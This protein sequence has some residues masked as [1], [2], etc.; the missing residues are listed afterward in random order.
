MAGWLES[1]LYGQDDPDIKGEPE[2]TEP[3]YSATSPKLI[4]QIHPFPAE[5]WGRSPSAFFLVILMEW[6]WFLWMDSIHMEI[7][8]Q[9]KWSALLAHASESY[10]A[11]TGPAYDMSGSRN[12]P[13]SQQRWAVY[14]LQS[15]PSAKIKAVC[16]WFA[17]SRWS[18]GAVRCLRD[19]VGSRDDRE[20]E[21]D[22][23]QTL[24]LFL[25]LAGIIKPSRCSLLN[26]IWVFIEESGRNLSK[27][28]A[29]SAS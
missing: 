6:P 10:L 5:E 13:T 2:G 28:C 20:K 12:L 29:L 22:T 18:S 14:H 16:I 3:P 7:W 11:L 26:R 4:N 19:L 15:T 27:I 21:P 9:G 17:V 23:L 8:S 24:W 1:S 25:H